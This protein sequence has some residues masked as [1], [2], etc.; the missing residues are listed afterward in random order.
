MED[1]LVSYTNCTSLLLS[2]QVDADLQPQ[3]C[4]LNLLL[5]DIRIPR[6]ACISNPV[7]R[8]GLSLGFDYGRQIWQNLRLFCWFLE[9]LR[10]VRTYTKRRS[11]S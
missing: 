6:R 7:L 5:P 2:S 1:H 8:R 9:L 4:R 3:H 10:M 11:R